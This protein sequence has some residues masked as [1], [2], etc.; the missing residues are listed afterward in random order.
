MIKIQI[1][2]KEVKQ[3]II[4]NNNND[5]NNNSRAL[6]WLAGAEINNSSLSKLPEKRKKKK[7]SNSFR[8]K[9]Q[10]CLL[11]VAPPGDTGCPPR[12]GDNRP[13]DTQQCDMSAVTN[14]AP[15]CFRIT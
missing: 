3:R 15:N 4:S 12:T 8:Y 11:S 6:L 7:N 5:N 13:E 9:V 2:F 10:G 1:K 14:I